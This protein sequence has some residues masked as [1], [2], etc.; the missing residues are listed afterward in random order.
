LV[1]LKSYVVINEVH[2]NMTKKASHLVVR[3]ETGTTS[4]LVPAGV[5][6][7]KS[8][9]CDNLSAEINDPLGLIAGKA[10]DG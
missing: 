5:L 7:E 10:S 6:A 8:D 9:P 1:L 2:T 4:H 3:M